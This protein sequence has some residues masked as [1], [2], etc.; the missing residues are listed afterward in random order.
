MK[1]VLAIFSSSFTHYQT[2]QIKKGV[3][4]VQKHYTE[5]SRDYFSRLNNSIYIHIMS[6][7]GWLVVLG[8]TAL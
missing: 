1:G 3:I 5:H 6:T 7:V 4:F 8:L 2:E